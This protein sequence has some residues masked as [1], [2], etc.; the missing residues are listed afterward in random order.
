MNIHLPAILG[1]TRYQGFD[2]SPFVFLVQCLFKY[3]PSHDLARHQFL[4]F[5][6]CKGLH[7]CGKHSMNV[8]HFHSFSELVF[9]CFFF[10]IL[11]G[12]VFLVSRS[13]ASPIPCFPIISPYLLMNSIRFVG[14]SQTCSGNPEKHIVGYMPIVS[15]SYSTIMSP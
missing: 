14:F 3:W 2:P 9:P 10:D 6:S 15:S 11:V 13:P 5:P 7:R 1:F 4:G 8:D 12:T